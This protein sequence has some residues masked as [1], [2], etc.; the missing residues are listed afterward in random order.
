MMN[1]CLIRCEYSEQ[2]GFGH[3]V[4][5]LALACELKKNGYRVS[6]LSASG[7]PDIDNSGLYAIDQWYT[8]SEGL[9]SAADAA[10]LVSVAREVGV[11]VVILDFYGISESYQLELREKGISWLQFDGWAKQPFW[12]DWVLS[13]SPAASEE[14]YLPLKK[15]SKTEFLLGPEY[16]ILRPEFRANRSGIKKGGAVR[17]VLLSLGGGDDQGRTLFCLKAISKL[18]WEGVVY[19]VVGK[20]NPNIPA[21]SAWIERSG[22]ENIILS[23]AEPEMARV[24]ASSDMAVISGGMT[25]F[26]AAVMGL[27]TLSMRIADNQRANVKAWS[28]LGVTKDL[29]EASDLT[30]ASLCYHFLEILEN[31]EMRRSMSQKGMNAVDGLGAERVVRLITQKRSVI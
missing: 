12:G 11:G 4:R 25:T 24:M 18:D 28:Q 15:G 10:N 14:R 27:P 6:V 5:C 20:A 17:Q 7:R 19:V 9:G 22:D 31:A 2:I 26:E 30:E 29:G 23:V 13:I 8:T 1:T 3:L 16:A 21:I